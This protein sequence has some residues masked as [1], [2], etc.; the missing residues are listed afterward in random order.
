MYG[1]PSNNPANTLFSHFNLLIN[2]NIL[3]NHAMVK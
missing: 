3:N 1:V 2:I